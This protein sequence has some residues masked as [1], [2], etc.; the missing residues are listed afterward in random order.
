MKW[1]RNF[2]VLV[3]VFI[4]MDTASAQQQTNIETDGSD[5]QPSVCDVWK[6]SANANYS[7]VVSITSN[8]LHFCSGIL[9]AP[10]WALTSLSCFKRILQFI[11]TQQEQVNNT[12]PQLRQPHSNSNCFEFANTSTS[13]MQGVRVSVSTA[14]DNC[15][16]GE[17]VDEFNVKAFVQYVVVHPKYRRI[18]VNLE[19][20][21]RLEDTD[22]EN[23]TINVN[24]LVLLKLGGSFRDVPLENIQLQ[25]FKYEKNDNQYKILAWVVQ[26]Q[27]FYLRFGFTDVIPKYFDNYLCPLDFRRDVCKIDESICEQ[28]YVCG[29][30]DLPK[31]TNNQYQFHSGDPLVVQDESDKAD[32]YGFFSEDFM[33]ESLRQFRPNGS[34]IP[35]QY[36]TYQY[37]NYSFEKN[38]AIF[39][40][41]T[42]KD[43]EREKSG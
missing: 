43:D 21:E 2:C 30:F 40:G 5:V 20:N 23:L 22:K 10:D 31:I 3:V 6:F 16:F 33:L 18:D 14:T 41:F 12:E 29:G 32:V 13:T 35:N 37:G 34:T 36:Y 28:L 27:N 1:M 17:D 26:Q 9:A 38:G 25:P 19:N 7:Y 42:E 11:Q 15:V 4:V 8:D 24:D 39:V